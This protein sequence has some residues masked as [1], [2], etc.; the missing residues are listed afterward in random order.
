MGDV[1]CS[2]R[3]QRV[4]GQMRS[5]W[6]E[7]CEAMGRGLS[8]LSAGGL[9]LSHRLPRLALRP[10]QPPTAPLESA[11]GISSSC[12]AASIRPR[13]SRAIS[14]AHPSSDRRFTMEGAADSALSSDSVTSI[15]LARHIRPA[16]TGGVLSSRNAPLPRH[17][18]HLC[19]IVIY[20]KMVVTCRDA[21]PPMTAI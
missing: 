18:F 7:C 10:A 5:R 9:P 12:R 6:K 13:P 19:H 17:N 15:C 14:P 2:L 3:R 8:F 4:I 16:L 1:G 21:M 20:I 11:T